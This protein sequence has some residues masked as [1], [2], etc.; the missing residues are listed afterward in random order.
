MDKLSYK[1]SYFNFLLKKVLV[2]M[3]KQ[4][5]LVLSIIIVLSAIYIIP[6]NGKTY[7]P[8]DQAVSGD[9]LSW[10]VLDYNETLNTVSPAQWWNAD[11]TFKGKYILH[12]GDTVTYTVDSTTECNGTLKIGNLTLTS[13]TRTDLGFNLNLITDPDWFPYN[14]SFCP[15]FITSSTDWN[16]QIE[17]ANNASDE[18]GGIMVVQI[19]SMVFLEEFRQVIFFNYTSPYGGITYAVYDNA[20]GILMYAYS[21][22]QMAR[23][24]LLVIIPEE[25]TSIPGFEILF[26]ILLL[27]WVGIGFDLR[28]KFRKLPNSTPQST[29]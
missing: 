20:T 14:Y 12:I 9:Q 5:F 3:K 8:F 15:A 16:E 23:L 26:S 1:L 2:K 17:L 19:T 27:I 4:I 6:S 29:I 21:Q 18:R 22:F 25:S 28:H 13:F 11:F 7:V 24:E 10:K